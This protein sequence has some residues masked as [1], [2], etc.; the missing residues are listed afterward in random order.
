MRERVAKGYGFD[1]AK[2]VKLLTDDRI[3]QEVWV[4]LKCIQTHVHVLLVLY[5]NSKCVSLHIV[6][7]RQRVKLTQSGCCLIN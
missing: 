4:W 7:S 6:S 1:A 5:Y 3:L 2:N